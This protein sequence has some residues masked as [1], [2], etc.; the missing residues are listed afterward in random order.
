MASPISEYTA[1]K[2]DIVE[3]RKAPHLGRLRAV[4]HQTK[5]RCDVG[6]RPGQYPFTLGRDGD[7]THDAVIAPAL[8][9]L[10]DH[11]PVRL[12]EHGLEPKPSRDLL[13]EI[14][15]KAHMYA[16]GHVL[17]RRVDEV[18]AD[19]K[20]PWTSVPNGSA[21]VLEESPIYRGGE[22]LQPWQRSF[23]TI[24]L[25]HRETYGQARLLLAD[26]VGLGKTLLLEKRLS[27]YEGSLD[28]AKPKNE[29]QKERIAE[30]ENFVA[31]AATSFR[32]AAFDQMANEILAKGKNGGGR[33]ISRSDGR[34]APKFRRP[35]KT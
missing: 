14:D 5:R 1:D 21:A 18:G 4:D 20:R 2:A 22:Q 13:H 34:P 32:D 6:N 33:T 16:L 17:K 11:L 9:F 27:V 29:Q 31:F 19:P 23:V 7:V 28:L 12:D 10:E 26:Q 24:F 3:V 8:H 25:Q 15:L 30:L 35:G